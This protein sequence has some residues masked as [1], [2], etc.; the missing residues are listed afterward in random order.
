MARPTCPSDSDEALAIEYIEALHADEAAEAAARQRAK[1][2][3][4]AA[5]PRKVAGM[6][7]ITRDQR[8]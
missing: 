1:T 5:G 7:D 4:L 6:L 8:P 2:A 3:L